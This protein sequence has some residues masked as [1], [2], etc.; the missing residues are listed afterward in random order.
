MILVLNVYMKSVV[1]LFTYH[2]RSEY[3]VACEE[4]YTEFN[5]N[6]LR[7]KVS[8]RMLMCFTTIF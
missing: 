4:P 6:N 3:K 2:V 5:I 8:V 1:P 7:F